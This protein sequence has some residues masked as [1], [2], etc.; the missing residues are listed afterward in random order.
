MADRP[1]ITMTDHEIRALLSRAEDVV[2]AG[3]GP[4][5]WPVATLAHGMLDDDRIVVDIPADDLVTGSLTDGADVC[6]IADEGSSYFDIRGVIGRGQ[7]TQVRP[8]PSM[9]R[10]EIRIDHVVSF[11]FAKLPE[12]RET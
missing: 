9:L 7:V 3:I 2:V 1:D 5:G 6:C 10:A 11:D 12:A 8:D 4:D